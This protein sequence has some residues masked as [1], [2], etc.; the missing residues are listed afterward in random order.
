MGKK[1]TKMIKTLEYQNNESTHNVRN[2]NL[3]DIENIARAMFEAYLGT[4][5]CQE[6][7]YEEALVEVKNI[8]NDGYGK[9]IPE[10]SFLIEQ[11]G[12]ASSVI[13]INYHEN[14]PMITEVFTGKEFYKKGM[15]S[16]LIKSSINALY[17]LKYDKLKLYVKD[18]NESAVSLYKKLGFEWE[19]D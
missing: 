5:D 10:A 17:D 16:A 2:V 3:S 18:E 1:R 13:L 9:F 7:C 15:A 8:F 14:T 19:M 4:V 11:D 12:E 6:E